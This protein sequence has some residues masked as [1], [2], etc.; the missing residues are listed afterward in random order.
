M[1]K[2]YQQLSIRKTETKTFM[3]Y[4]VFVRNYYRCF[5]PYFVFSL[6][7][8]T[9]DDITSFDSSSTRNN[10]IISLNLFPSTTNNY[11]QAFSNLNVC[12]WYPPHHFRKRHIHILHISVFIPKFFEVFYLV[13]YYVHT[14][15]S[16]FMEKL[17]KRVKVISL[18]RQSSSV[19]DLSNI[20][21]GH[22]FHCIQLNFLL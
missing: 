16:F 9:M 18:Q 14:R 4:K 7:L 12:T 22:F 6:S 13:H 15:V 2:T 8:F 1:I 10:H 11:K 20:F 19:L 5:W 21:Q 3:L 17:C